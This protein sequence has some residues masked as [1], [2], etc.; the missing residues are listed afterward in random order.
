M[1]LVYNSPQDIDLFSGGMSEIPGNAGAMVGPTFGCV[2][3]N[4]FHNTKFGDR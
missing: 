1:S 3:A 2:I 4:Q